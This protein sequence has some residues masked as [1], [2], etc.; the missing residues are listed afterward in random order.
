MKTRAKILRAAYAQALAS[1]ALEG[2]EQPEDTKELTEAWLSGQITGEEY[3][4]KLRE[5]YSGE[6]KR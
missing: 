6:A 5:H 1:A 2:L 4:A 3:R